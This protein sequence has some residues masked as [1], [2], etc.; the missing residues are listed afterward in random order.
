M[1]EDA[2]I[3]DKVARLVELI[4]DDVIPVIEN[5]GEIATN[6]GVDEIKFTIKGEGEVYT[7]DFV[8]DYTVIFNVR[9]TGG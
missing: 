6:L 5:F 2:T 8:C 7:D 4:R 3:K 1:S 9:Q